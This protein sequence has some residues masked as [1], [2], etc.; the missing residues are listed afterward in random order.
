MQLS[1]QGRLLGF[2]FEYNVIFSTYFI[3]RF[4]CS[5]VMNTLLKHISHTSVYTYIVHVQTVT[6]IKNIFVGLTLYITRNLSCG[7]TQEEVAV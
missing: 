2:Q 3:Y 6:L 7:M 5:F 4:T 1:H